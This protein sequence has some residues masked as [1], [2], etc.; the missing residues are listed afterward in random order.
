M[1]TGK[2]ISFG[3]RLRL[4]SRLFRRRWHRLGTHLSRS[5]VDTAVADRLFQLLDLLFVFDLY[6]AGCNLLFPGIRQLTE[7]EV[8]ILRPIFGSSLPYEMMRI[9]ERAW[10]GPRRYQFCYV[11]FHT[12]NSW[13]P[14]SEAVLVHE[15]VHVWQYVQFGACYIPRAL[16][17][18]RTPM[19]YNYGALK[20]LAAA[21]FLDD[22]NYEQMADVIEDV[23]RLRRGLPP[24]WLVHHHPG[25]HLH[26]TH[27][28]DQL[29]VYLPSAYAK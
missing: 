2:F 1:L 19:G 18:Q 27:F 15:A 7:R 5:V 26:F 29:K 10:F 25:T 11:S 22:F 17:A 21:A 13:G 23:F 3:N 4:G 8:G 28:V 14:M 6:E 24:K 9:D 12:I 20:G 16:S